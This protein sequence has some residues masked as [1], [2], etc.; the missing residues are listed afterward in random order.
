M[1]NR[2]NRS[3]PSSTVIPVLGYADV[4]AAALWLE[5]AFGF[6]LRIRMGDHRAQMEVGDGAVVLTRVEGTPA[7]QTVMVRVDDVDGHYAR[8]VAAGV[9]VAGEPVTYPYGERQYQAF[10][11]AGHEWHFSESVRDVEPEEWGGVRG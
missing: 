1:S 5:Q 9:T 2:A 4:A 10:D 8:A 3:M 11:L 6:V 7:R